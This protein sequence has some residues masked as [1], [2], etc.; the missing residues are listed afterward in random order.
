MT[1]HYFNSGGL[2]TKLD[3]IRSGLNSLT[4]IP[5][6]FAIS[7]SN[8]TQDI[9][10]SDLGFCDFQVF[11]TDRSLMTSN[12]KEGGGVLICVKNNI[13]VTKISIDGDIIEQ[14]F[15]KISKFKLIIGLVYIPPYA[16]ANIYQHHV[17]SVIQISDNHPEYKLL[18]LGDYNIPKV[19]WSNEE[20]LSTTFLDK[21]QHKDMEHSLILKDNFSSL[22]LSQHFKAR[23]EKGYTLDLCFSDVKNINVSNGIDC[24]LDLDRH[25]DYVELNVSLNLN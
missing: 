15:I 11:R 3:D 22:N 17:D 2:R 25:H 4:I 19:I 23:A 8:L 24:L 12:K 21:I 16:S 5:D 7:E 14:V 6:I 9:K 1:V 10:D 18:L 20:D 13:P